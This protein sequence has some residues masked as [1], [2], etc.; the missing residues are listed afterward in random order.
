MY[1]YDSKNTFYNVYCAIC[2]EARHLSYWQV[3]LKLKNI[4]SAEK[5][6]FTEM[7]NHGFTWTVAK[8]PHHSTDYCVPTPVLQ[9]KYQN[10]INKNDTVLSSYCKSYA[11]PV[12]GNCGKLKNP[13]CT[14]LH[15]EK[16]KTVSCREE[17][18]CN[19]NKDHYLSILFSFK[20]H[21]AINSDGASN[22]RVINYNCDEGKIYDPFTNICRKIYLPGPNTRTR[23]TTAN[24]RKTFMN[25]TLC[26]KVLYNGSAFVMYNNG[27]VFITSQKKLYPSETYTVTSN[28]IALCTNYSDTRWDPTSQKF[29]LKDT[30]ASTLTVV[31]SLVSIVC[32]LCFVFTRLC[33]N[34]LRTLY[35][36]NLTSLSCALLVFQLVFLLTGQTGNTTICDVI[37]GAVHY[38]LLALF[39]WMSVMAFDVSSKF[40]TRGMLL[41]IRCNNPNFYKNC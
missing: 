4:A 31:G 37:T 22:G 27:S 3:K 19:T 13:H 30:T 1:D 9:Q 16:L 36:K 38:S 24:E 7:L 25:G 23:N 34:E 26:N 39:A 32:L 14:Y 8:Y 10:N 2:N 20:Q 28:A 21:D 17:I 40:T 11:L 5:Y 35:G 18:P 41:V 15:R 6:S 12:F 29:E 33:F